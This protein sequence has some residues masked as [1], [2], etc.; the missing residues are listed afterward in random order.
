VVG[1]EGRAKNLA[2]AAAEAAL[3]LEA[4]ATAKKS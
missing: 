4:L 1:T 2:S 3:G